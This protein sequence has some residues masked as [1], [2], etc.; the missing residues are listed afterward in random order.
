M[1]NK[2][3]CL[4]FAVEN[5][6]KLFLLTFK[7]YKIMKTN[8]NLWN[9]ANLPATINIK[10]YE[11]HLERKEREQSETRTKGLQTLYFGSIICENGDTIA[12]DGK[13][14]TWVKNKVGD[15]E[16][17]VYTSLDGSTTIPK[18]KDLTDEVIMSM[19][20][21]YEYRLLHKVTISQLLEELSD[22][23]RDNIA[24]L[25]K[26]VILDKCQKYRTKLEREQRE[27]AEREQRE[28]E[29]QSAQTAVKSAKSIDTS[30]RK[31][32]IQAQIVQATLAG[33]IAK[34]TELAQLLAL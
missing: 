28:R 33:D 18:C 25:V 32:M 16:R 20:E 1:E 14:L 8:V 4:I 3:R 5:N 27:R 6:N 7:T 24:P 23:D 11:V 26:G 22:Y 29:R 15:K 17:R 30:T 2:K 12:I 10:D 21:S 34:V 19:V 13:P 31:G 9:T